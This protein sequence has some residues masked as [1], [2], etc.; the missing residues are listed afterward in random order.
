MPLRCCKC[1]HRLD[2]MVLSRCKALSVNSPRGPHLTPR[3]YPSVSSGKRTARWNLWWLNDRPN[4]PGPASDQAGTWTPTLTPLKQSGGEAG[5]LDDPA[6]SKDGAGRLF[7][8]KRML[9]HTRKSEY[10]F[11]MR[12][13]PRH[14]ICRASK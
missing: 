2:I 14:D 7:V 5:K 1:S 4:I 10:S 12:K 3:R 6:L 9:S 11:R 13:D 8:K